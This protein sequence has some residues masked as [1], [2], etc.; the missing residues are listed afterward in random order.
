MQFVVVARK[1]ALTQ[2]TGLRQQER[3]LCR[4]YEQQCTTSAAICRVLITRGREQALTLTIF[5]R[6]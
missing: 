2:Y 1:K 4:Q 5:P 3:E 6:A